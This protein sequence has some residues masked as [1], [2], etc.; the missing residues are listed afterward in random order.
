MT[1][2]LLPTAVRRTD[3]IVDVVA[4]L[5]LATGVALFAMGRQALGALAAGT[6]PA[7]LGET[8]VARADFHAA[9]TQ[10][11]ALLIVAGLAVGAI[12][13]LR[14]LQHRQMQ[15]RRAAAG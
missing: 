4:A 12:G 13:A 15:R 2:P 14:H 9:Q 3:R 1:E 5:L 7:P 10:W 11:G 8:W 6:Y